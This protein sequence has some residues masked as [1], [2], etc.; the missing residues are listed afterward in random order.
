MIGVC[1]G[2][3]FMAVAG[4]VLNYFIMIPFYVKAFGTPLDGI[5]AAGK[6]INP[7]VGSKL[8]F[9][10][11]CVAPFNIIKGV[12]DSIITFLLYKRISTFIKSIG[13]K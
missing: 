1:A 4:V 12:I 2:T 3:V 13:H 7:L 8:S 11:V 10:I 9:A 5:L 6:S